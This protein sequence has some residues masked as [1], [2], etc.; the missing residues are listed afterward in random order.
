MTWFIS[1]SDIIGLIVFGIIAPVVVSGW[2]TLRIIE[3]YTTKVN[4]VHW[5]IFIAF[6]V[7][8]WAAEGAAVAWWLS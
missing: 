8:L 2:I 7:V 6:A 5:V 3:R 1:T 4:A